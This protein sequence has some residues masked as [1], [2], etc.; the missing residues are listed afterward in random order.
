MAQLAQMGE[1]TFGGP[2]QLR[3]EDD[4]PAPDRF[5]RVGS[6]ATAPFPSRP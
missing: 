3:D 5:S 4:T 2:R 6:V 1:Q